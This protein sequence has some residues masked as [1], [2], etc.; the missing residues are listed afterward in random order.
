MFWF[1]VEET[2]NRS[3]S[4]WLELSLSHQLVPAYVLMIGID[5]LPGT[6]FG[7]LIPLFLVSVGQIVPGSDR[8]SG[9]RS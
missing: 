2:C 1:T 3:L 4:T 5:Y 9:R 8:V 7:Q 6:V